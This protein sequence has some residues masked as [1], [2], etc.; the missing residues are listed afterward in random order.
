M[1][2]TDTKLD[3]TAETQAAT[4]PKLAKDETEKLTTGVT[5]DKPNE[6]D[7]ASSATASKPQT[8]GDMASSA[9]SA[10]KDNVFGMFGGG[11]KKEKKADEG[12]ADEPSGSSKKKAEDV[13]AV[14]P[15]R[16]SRWQGRYLPSLSSMLHKRS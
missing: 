2:D 16:R 14:L 11:P 5:E 1:A 4:E 6:G 15:Q 9:T 12:D 7:T 3:P 10:V 8:F 13:S